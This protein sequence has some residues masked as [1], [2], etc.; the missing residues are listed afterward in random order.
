MELVDDFGWRYADGR[1][2]EASLLFDDDINEL[3]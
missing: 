1:N 2:E 3:R